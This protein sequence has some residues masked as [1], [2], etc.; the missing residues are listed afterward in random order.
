MDFDPLC[1]Y[2]L[3]CIL[4][5]IYVPDTSTIKQKLLVDTSAGGQLVPEDIIRP[6]VSDSARDMVY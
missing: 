1:Y 6:V 2:L 4:L 5:D 3:Q